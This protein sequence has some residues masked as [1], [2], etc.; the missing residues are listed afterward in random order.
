M[1]E[2]AQLKVQYRSKC[3]KGANRKLRQTGIVPGIFYSYDGENIPVQVEQLPLSRVFGEVGLSQIIELEIERDGKKTTRP[4]LI[5][6]LIQHPVK[7]MYT[8]VDFFGLDMSNDVVV[9]VPVRLVGKSQGEVLGGEL[10]LFRDTLELRCKPAN[11]PDAIDVDITNLQLNENILVEE[12]VLPEGT[13]AVY[14]EVFAVVGL[15]VP[16][17]SVEEEEGEEAEAEAEV[18]QESSEG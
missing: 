5:K 15:V 2:T 12:L 6:S 7:R 1:S 3:G 4:A 14:E 16:A 8:H 11:I 9:S 10:Q 17:A 18:D 13:E